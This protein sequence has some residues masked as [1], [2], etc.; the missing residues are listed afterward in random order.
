MKKKY[1]GSNRKKRPFRNSATTQ[2]VSKFFTVNNAEMTYKTTGG[3]QISRHSFSQS[4]YS[5]YEI[6]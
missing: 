3:T 2:C 6:S 4:A 5:K 1:G